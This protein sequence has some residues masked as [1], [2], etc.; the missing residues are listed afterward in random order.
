MEDASPPTAIPRVSLVQAWAQQ[1]A[2]PYYSCGTL[3]KRG[4]DV[5]QKNSHQEC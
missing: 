3:E 5:K 4:V 2:K 1:R